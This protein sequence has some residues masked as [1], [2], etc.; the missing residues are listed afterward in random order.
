[1]RVEEKGDLRGEVIHLQAGLYRRVDIGDRVRQREGHFCTAVAPA[2]RM[3]YPL[4]EMV[5]QLGIS[6]AQ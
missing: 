2:S 3:W 4:T 1:M 5:F 6:R